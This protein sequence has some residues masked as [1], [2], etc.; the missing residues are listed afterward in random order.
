VQDVQWHGDRV[1]LVGYSEYDARWLDRS[2]FALLSR[3]DGRTPWRQALDQANAELDEPLPASLVEDL[4]RA[5]ALEEAGEVVEHQPGWTV[6][7]LRLEGRELLVAPVPVDDFPL[8]FLT[9][10]A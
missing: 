10:G 5:D 6:R 4:W 1:F 8:T 9:D 3:L 7:S 2:V